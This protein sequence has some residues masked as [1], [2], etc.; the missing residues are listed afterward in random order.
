MKTIA[1]K[2]SR[3]LKLSAIGGFF[4]ICLVLFIRSGDHGTGSPSWGM[5]SSLIAKKAPWF[6]PD[7][8]GN[9]EPEEEPVGDGPGEGGKAYRL[10]PHDQNKA[11][12]SIGNYGMNMAVSNAISLER[13]IPDTR[14]EE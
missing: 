5:K 13:A 6:T 10:P 8:L 2:R 4:L 3:V 14:Q 9:F 7:K 1:W 12:E 11:D